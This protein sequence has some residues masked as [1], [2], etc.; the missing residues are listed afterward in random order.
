MQ[1]SQSFQQVANNEDIQWQALCALN[2]CKSAAMNCVPT[3]LTGSS[4]IFPSSLES[5]EFYRMWL[6]R[7]LLSN[8]NSLIHFLPMD[9]LFTAMFPPATMR[10]TCHC[11]SAP[12]VCVTQF[13]KMTHP[14]GFIQQTKILCEMFNDYYWQSPIDQVK[15]QNQWCESVR[16]FARFSFI[17]NK[18]PLIF[19]LYIW[20]FTI[21]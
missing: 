3:S 6:K 18:Y 16:I 11:S 13:Y 15:V 19:G 9:F 5:D 10:N 1:L 4:G 2:V 14:S 20:I 21:L 8:L 17:Q 7:I 12:K